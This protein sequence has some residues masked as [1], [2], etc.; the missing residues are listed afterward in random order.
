MKLRNNTFL[1]SSSVDYNHTDL[2]TIIT[3]LLNNNLQVEMGNNSNG[4]YIKFSNGL[5]ICLYSYGQ[6]SSISIG[7]NT[8]TDKTFTF[9]IPFVG[10][11]LVLPVVFTDSTSYND[12][13]NFFA[14]ISSSSSTQC[15]VRLFRGSGS[16]RYP[17][18]NYLA[19]GKWK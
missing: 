12:M 18:I 5:L 16:T 1:D 14:S 9:A 11:P 19:I 17:V 3:N 8:Y 4:E 10:T 2:K 7:T 15:K 13:Q 6:G